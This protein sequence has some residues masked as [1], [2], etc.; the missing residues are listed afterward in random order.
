MLRHRSVLNEGH[1]METAISL[2]RDSLQKDF[3]IFIS[4]VVATAKQFRLE[5][6]LKPPSAGG[7]FGICGHDP[8]TTL[9]LVMSNTVGLHEHERGG[10]N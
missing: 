9:Q 2:I 1:S 8:Q 10:R 7:T 5:S 3:R 4:S 6:P